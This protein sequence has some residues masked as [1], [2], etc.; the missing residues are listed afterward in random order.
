MDDLE[1]VVKVFADVEI[2]VI[3]TLAS[4]AGDDVDGFED[5]EDTA[6]VEVCPPRAKHMALQS[7]WQSSFATT[8][9]PPALG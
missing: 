2:D 7:T 3:C 5:G 1:G 4:R 6:V 9:R 8:A